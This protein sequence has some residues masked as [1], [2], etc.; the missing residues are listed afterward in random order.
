MVGTGKWG[1]ED[2]KIVFAAKVRGASDELV[3]QELLQLDPRRNLKKGS[4]KYVVDHFKNFA[5]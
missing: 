4:I 1:T 5:E 2:A 3:M